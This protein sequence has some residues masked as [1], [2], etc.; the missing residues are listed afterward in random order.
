MNTKLILGLGLLVALSACQGSCSCGTTDN[1]D[2][3]GG[4]NEG[5]ATNVSVNVSANGTGGAGEG[6]GTGGDGTGGNGTGGNGTGGSAPIVDP[7]IRF[8]NVSTNVRDVTFCLRDDGD[9]TL[10]ADSVDA[11]ASPNV[12]GYAEVPVGNYLIELRDD[13]AGCEDD[14]SGTGFGPIPLGDGAVVSFA[15]VGSDL[16]GDDANILVLDDALAFPAAGN[17][18]LRFVHAAT[19]APNVDIGEY[20]GEQFVPYFLDVAYTEDA[21]YG[22]IPDGVLAFENATLVAR[23]A[24][25]ESDLL[26]V[27]EVDGPDG[28]IVN[29]FAI[30]NIADGV[31]AWTFVDAPV[32]N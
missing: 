18:K 5:G 7:S 29:A 12:T 3:V 22:S 19:G 28:A 10:V 20:D 30:G 23:A 15:L 6:G 11:V 26:E 2:G 17:T 24:G 21:G 16:I 27:P 32:A 9:N 13:G 31:A 1:E 14:G 8:I 4:S 25:S